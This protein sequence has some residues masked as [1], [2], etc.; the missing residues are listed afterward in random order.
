MKLNR[1]M[2]F[3]SVLFLINQKIYSYQSK[4]ND[5][6]LVVTKTTTLLTR[7]QYDILSALSIS[8]IEISMTNKSDHL[9]SFT[10][11]NVHGESLSTVPLEKIIAQKKNWW[12]AI[13]LGLSSAV[14]LISILDYAVSKLL[15]DAELRTVWPDFIKKGLS[16]LTDQQ[17]RMVVTTCLATRALISTGFGTFCLSK[18]LKN[19][20]TITTINEIKKEILEKNTTVIPQK[21]IKKII[22]IKKGTVKKCTVTAHDQSTNETTIFEVDLA[23]D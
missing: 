7:Q 8:P 13:G 17:V 1:S 5:I 15:S 19:R 9:I 3:L 16:D 10:V 11:T 22:L 18:L 20:K 12:P 2:F 4:Q 21:T 23:A 6:E 14:I